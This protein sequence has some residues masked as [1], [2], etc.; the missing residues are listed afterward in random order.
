MATVNTLGTLGRLASF[1]ATAAGG[2]AAQTIASGAQYNH[3]SALTSL[4][5]LGSTETR[6]Y[7]V[8][9]QLTRITGLGL[10]LEY[11]FSTT[12]NDGKITA[13][14]NWVSG[15]E[16]AYQYDSLERLI[17][18]VTTGP[19]WGLSFSY[20]GFGNRLSQTVTKGTAPSNS[21]LVDGTTNRISSAGFVYDLNGNMT[22]MPTNTAALTYDASNRM[23]QYSGTNISEAYA[24]APDNKRIWRSNTMRGCEVPNTPG[25][26][27]PTPQPGDA[28]IFYS[29]HGLKLGVY[30]LKDVG[31]TRFQIASE[32][33]LYFGGRFVARVGL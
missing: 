18:A 7:N 19:Q 14:K 2:V 16:V 28:I 25:Q 33:N 23:T 6:T 13:Q 10:D 31:G 15:E 5:V 9:G 22:N 1:T 24:Y 26:S 20:D 21:V 3:F 4:N 30:C 11:T 12:Q 17:S 29:A 8:L 27:Q 32:Q